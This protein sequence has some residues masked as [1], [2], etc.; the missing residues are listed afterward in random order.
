MYP[1]REIKI[2]EY[3]WPSERYVSELVSHSFIVIENISNLWFDRTSTFATRMTVLDTRLLNNQIKYPLKNWNP[4]RLKKLLRYYFHISGVVCFW[5]NTIY[6]Y[7]YFCLYRWDRYTNNQKTITFY[8]LS[9]FNG[10][11]N[12]IKLMCSWRL[13]LL[14]I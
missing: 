14:I 3:T 7:R 10:T 8:M 13:R 11:K 5:L 6:V 9:I 4:Y 1:R 12:T 2:Y